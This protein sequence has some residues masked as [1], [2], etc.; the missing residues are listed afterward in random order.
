MTTYLQHS[1]A[2]LQRTLPD[3][4]L[5]ITRLPAVEQI[6]LALI[7]TDFQTG[8]LPADA[9]HRVIAN[10]A[11]WAFCWG[12]GLALAR[13]ILSS[14]EFVANKRIV[15]VGCGCGVGAI[16]AK[17]AGAAEVVACD[18]DPD[19]LMVTRANAELNGVDLHYADDV[20]ELSG[21][22][23]LILMA[24]VLYDKSNYPLL[25][26]VKDL[27]TDI[28]VADSRIQTI[29]DPSFTAFY[30]S[31]ALT[32]PNLGEFDEFKDVRFFRASTS[33]ASHQCRRYSH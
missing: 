2:A 19:A 22:F 4:E 21:H 16:A 12:S 32:Y 31:E 24:D 8:P 23:D 28:I 17:L 7:N 10:P 3:A 9:M 33:L 13:W 14:A 5:E 15:D 29:D 20:T 27:A 6:Q 25:E 11:Y 26:T 18:N 1:L 30:Q